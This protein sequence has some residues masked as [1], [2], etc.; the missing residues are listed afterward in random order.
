MDARNLSKRLLTV[1]NYVPQDASLA[2]I[3]SDHAYLPAYLALK[4]QIRFAVAGEV[5]RGPYENACHELRKEGLTDIIKARL[6]NGLEAIKVTD[7]IDTITI[8][9]MGGP[10]ICNILEDGRAKLVNHPRLIL[11][12]NV[13]AADVR[14]WLMQEEYT[15]VAEEILSEDGHIYEIIVADYIPNQ[16]HMTDLDLEFGV[17]L[18]KEKNAAFIA[19]WSEEVH[20]MKR[21][22]QQMDKAKVV[23]LEKK[24]L[25][26]DNIARIEGVLHGES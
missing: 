19:K 11:Q 20:K 3:G 23:P 21:V 14:C 18:R 26:E 13:G 12:P 5:V 10:L 15:V 17:Y 24:Q 16:A 22:I 9:G 1:A 4:G 6:A 2:D 7:K 25:L 8:C